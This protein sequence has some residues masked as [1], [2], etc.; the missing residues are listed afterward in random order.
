MATSTTTKAATTATAIQGING[1]VPTTMKRLV[2]QAPGQDVATCQIAVQQ[3]S[4]PVLTSRDD[5]LIQVSAAA[6]NP[7]DYG[8]WARCRPEQCPVAMGN[9]GCGIVVKNG[10]GLV[11]KL[12]FPVGTKVAFVGL[13]NKQGAYS[14]YV[15][16][17]ARGDAVFPIQDNVPV[18][19]AAAFIVNPFTS[20]AILDSVKNVEHSNCFVH[21][22]AAS[23]LGQMLV[24]VAPSEG[25][26]I[27]NVVRREEQATLLHNIGA[28]HVVVE[29][30]DGSWKQQ[31]KTKIDELKATVAFD[32]VA[33]S[34]SSDLLQALP[35]KGTVYVYGGLAGKVQ[36]IDPMDLI[37]KGK[38]LKG[39]FLRDWVT[40]GG[41]LFTAMLRVISATRRVNSGL[42]DGG[43]SSSQFQDTTMENMQNDLV[44]LMKSGITGKKLRIRLDAA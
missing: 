24:R 10:G 21:T 25:I 15:T 33:G 43:W 6:V 29:N 30:S 8:T 9:E 39:F 5:L 38:K 22:A 16:V 1:V 26:E 14:Q 18:E 12:R 3:V 35:E 41:N 19:D 32:A 2:V 23:Q 4:V 37:Y 42:I 17:N 44:K 27:I 28:K 13:K 31:L 34:S 7:S 40:G 20:L 36:D 11:A